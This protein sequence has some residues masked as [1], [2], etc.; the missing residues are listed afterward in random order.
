MAITNGET[1]MELEHVIGL[2]VSCHNPSY[3]LSKTNEN[4]NEQNENPNNEEK[5]SSSNE[6]N[7]DYLSVCGSSIILSSFSDPHSQT[8]LR[9][10]TSWI[11]CCVVS[12][13]KHWIASSQYGSRPD[14][15]VW[16]GGKLIYKLEQHEKAVCRMTFSKD[17][18]FLATVG[19]SIDGKMYI[20]DMHSGYIVTSTNINPSP[21]NDIVSGGRVKDIKRRLTTDYLFATCGKEQVRIWAMTPSTGKL[22]SEKCKTSNLH[23]IRNF[24]CLT[25]SDTADL[26]IAGTSSGDFFIFDVRNLTALCSYQPNCVGGI[27]KIITTQLNNS[28]IHDPMSSHYFIQIIVGCGDGNISIWKYNDDLEKFIEENKIITNDGGGI[29]T[30]DINKNKNKLLIATT[31]GNIHE[32]EIDDDDNKINKKC[33][34]QNNKN[35]DIILMQND[36]KPEEKNRKS[37]IICCN[38]T[39]S[40]IDIKFPLNVSDSFLTVSEYGSIRKWSINDYSISLRHDTIYGKSH[41]KNL[42]KAI[43]FDFNDE[44]IITG[45]QD[46]NIRAY[47]S[48]KSNDGLLW[49]IKD[50]Q[51]FQGGVSCLRLG[52]NQK[53]IISCGYDG[54]LRCWDI[55]FKKLV[56]NLKE[57]TSSI[58]GIALYSDSRHVLTCS[59][60]RSFIC[61]DL[62]T[63]KRIS[64]HRQNM[65]TINDIKLTSDENIV[66]TCGGD[67]CITF[68][69]IRQ[70]KPTNY[71]EQAHNTDINCIGLGNKSNTNLIITA[72]TQ[73]ILKLWDIKTFKLVNKQQAFCGKING[74]AFSADDKQIV[75]VGQDSS[76]MLWNIFKM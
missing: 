12:P 50:A 49:E 70:S 8:F 31:S 53:Y 21:C 33:I 28:Y 38:E 76:I 30:M 72:D 46:G 25:F 71:I 15:Y 54:S 48:N 41:N 56:A 55:R 43:C 22:L 26:L 4:N 20:W 58:N 40:I 9:G 5:E 68:W 39:S 36:G 2:N 23:S 60:D 34:K 64:C 69:D 65:G 75:S 27:N 10:H 11:E 16:N 29:I 35:D 6:N 59:K 74:V 66:I 61:W 18:R 37:K 63:Q 13:N 73:S 3:Y 24:T 47:N 67:R 44:I 57:H 32:I 42:N 7:A 62:G 45:W 14:V 1:V 19:S 17:S 51:T 52:Y